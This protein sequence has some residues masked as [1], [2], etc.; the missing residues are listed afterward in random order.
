MHQDTESDQTTNANVITILCTECGN[1]ES[2][3]LDDLLNDIF[4]N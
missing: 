1:N 2:Y 3:F 4:R